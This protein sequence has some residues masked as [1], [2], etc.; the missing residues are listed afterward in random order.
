MLREQLGRALRELG[1]RR[2]VHGDAIERRRVDLGELGAAVGDTRE[3]LE[4]ANRVLIGD[5]L[6]E[7]PRDCGERSP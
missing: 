6:L 7:Q 5:I 3:S 1:G 2:L 4:L